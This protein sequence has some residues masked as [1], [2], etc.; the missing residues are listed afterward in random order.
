MTKLELMAQV[1]CAL[2]AKG[3]IHE[4]TPVEEVAEQVELGA[5]RFLEAVGK[6]IHVDNPNVP[7]KIDH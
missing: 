2:I 1:Y 5:D 7:L 6:M 4:H 3:E